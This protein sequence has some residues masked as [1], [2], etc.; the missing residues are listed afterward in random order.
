MSALR[1]Q[2]R[3]AERPVRPAVPEVKT[4]GVSAMDNGFESLRVPPFEHR[5][6]AAAQRVGRARHWIATVHLAAH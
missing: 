1:K 6:C 3:E 2:F 5:W 4:V